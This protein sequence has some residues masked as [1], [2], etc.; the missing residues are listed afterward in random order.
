MLVKDGLMW[1]IQKLLIYFSSSTADLSKQ[2]FLKFVE[3]SLKKRK[4]NISGLDWVLFCFIKL[5]FSLVWYSIC[6]CCLPLCTLSFMRYFHHNA[7]MIYSCHILTF[8]ANLLL[9]SQSCAKPTVVAGSFKAKR[10]KLLLLTSIL[11]Q[12]QNLQLCSLTGCL[13][14]EWQSKLSNILQA[15]VSCY[16]RLD[17]LGR[18]TYFCIICCQ[19]LCKQFH[20]N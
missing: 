16:G 10:Y 1:V 14:P 4:Y 19:I 6:N 20:I 15:I 7:K 9:M 2:P 17:K 12:V 3:N 5:V 11:Q 18:L 8:H 13:N